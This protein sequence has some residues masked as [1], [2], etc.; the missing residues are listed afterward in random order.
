[1]EHL[2]EIP[3]FPKDIIPNPNFPNPNFPNIRIPFPRIPIIPKGHCPESLFS[4]RDIVPNLY[5]PEGTLSRIPTFPKGHF[6]ESHFPEGTLSQIHISQKHCSQGTI[7]HHHR[8]FGN[9]L[10]IIVL[11]NDYFIIIV[12]LRT[13]FP[14]F[15]ENNFHI[16]FFIGYGDAVLLILRKNT[17]L[18]NRDIIPSGKWRFGI[19]SLRENGNSDDIP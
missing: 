17:W 9:D 15:S 13:I 1:M 8:S 5:F 12:P 4:R 10:I 18:K 14:S 3:N 7:I 19:L 11:R 2:T 16:R 6:P